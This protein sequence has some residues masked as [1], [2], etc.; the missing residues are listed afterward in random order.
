MTAKWVESAG[1]PLIPLPRPLLSSWGGCPPDCDD[2]LD[3]RHD[4]G[5]ACQVHAWLEEIPVGSGVGIIVDGDPLSTAWFPR[6]DG[7]S[8]F[9]VRWLFAPN[10]EHVLKVIESLSQ[11]TF[12]D[13]LMTLEVGGEALA[14]FDSVLPGDQ[15]EESDYVDIHL[16]RGVYTISTAEF[17]PDP[18]TL[19][20]VHRF[21]RR[22][23][24]I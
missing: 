22:T 1:G 21:V 16:P 18:R 24:G 3:P 15:A 20:I 9:L 2:V 17:K 19:L 23:I 4:Y 11:V 6:V 7:E 5:R 14:L 8:G 10:E 13:P 12:G